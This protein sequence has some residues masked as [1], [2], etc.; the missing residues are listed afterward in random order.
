[1]NNFDLMSDLKLIEVKGVHKRTCGKMHIT[2]AKTQVVIPT[3]KARELNWMQNERIN[4]YSFDATTLVLKPDET[5]LFTARYIN[6]VGSTLRISSKALCIEIM[7]RMNHSKEFK[8]WVVGNMLVFKPE[9]S[10]DNE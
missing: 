1:M 2:N 9:R 4:L 6:E 8:S 10:N 7:A 5:G 3:D